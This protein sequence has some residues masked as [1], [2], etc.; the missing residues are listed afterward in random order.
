MVSL[1]WRLPFPLFSQTIHSEHPPQFYLLKHSYLL[2]YREK[3]IY[4][5]CV[6]RLK[7]LF[8]NMFPCQIVRIISVS[9]SK[10]IVSVWWIYDG[11]KLLKVVIFR[12]LCEHNHTISPF[13]RWVV[14]SH[15]LRSFINVGKVRQ[16]R[17]INSLWKMGLNKKINSSFFFSFHFTWL[18]CK[19]EQ[20]FFSP[21]E[22]TK[23]SAI[24]RLSKVELCAE[25]H[26][27]IL[28]RRAA[29]RNRET[30]TLEDKDNCGDDVA[31]S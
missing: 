3:N 25:F 5:K 24:A 28:Q 19:Y 13:I 15:N 10:Q 30:S 14:T 22:W 31:V 9:S 6:E 4:V 21:R 27:E 11:I 8:V 23:L 29:A 1:H 7:D 20:L 2:V 18:L 12:L 16:N 26:R 17:K